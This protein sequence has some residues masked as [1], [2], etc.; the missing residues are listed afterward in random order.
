MEDAQALPAT[1]PKPSIPLAVFGA[2]LV[3]L[4]LWIWVGNSNASYLIAAVSFAALTPGFYFSP[5]RF[6]RSFLA[7]AEAIRT[8]KQPAWV[9]G[10]TIAGLALLF[11]S[12]AVR[13]LG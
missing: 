4:N 6:R 7:N 8:I 13:W 10:S 2:A 5:I 3:L 9:T 1:T 11:A 12:L